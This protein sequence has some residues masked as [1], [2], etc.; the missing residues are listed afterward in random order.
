MAEALDNDGVWTIR[1]YI[2]CSQ[3]TVSAQV[4]LC[5]IYNMCTG[6]ER[7]LGTSRFL[8]WL[9]QDVGREVE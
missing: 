3:N 8:R 9:Y 1:K 2:H 7:I 6:A 5:T 4:V